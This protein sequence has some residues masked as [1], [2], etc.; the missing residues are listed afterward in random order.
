MPGLGVLDV[1][2][3]NRSE[4]S[5]RLKIDLAHISRVLN[6]KRSPSLRLAMRMADYLGVTVE[7]LTV[8]IRERGKG[9]AGTGAV[10]PGTGGSDV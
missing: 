1:S 7:G 8:A 5:R 9:G 6:G 10:E 3:V 2:A 4:M